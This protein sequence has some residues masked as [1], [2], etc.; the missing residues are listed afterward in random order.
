ME[1]IWTFGLLEHVGLSFEGKRGG[2]GLGVAVFPCHSRLPFVWHRPV[3]PASIPEEPFISSDRLATHSIHD[4][5][6]N[7]S[8]A[9]FS[10]SS[11]AVIPPTPSSQPS[12]DIIDIPRIDETLL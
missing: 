9:V 8:F 3:P 1:V 12:Y 7:H 11:S 5:K 10:F 6:S 4:G 2:G